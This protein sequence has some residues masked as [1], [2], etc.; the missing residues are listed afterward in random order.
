MSIIDE[1]WSTDD[2]VQLSVHR[3]RGLKRLVG[4]IGRRVPAAGVALLIPRCRAVHGIGL[5]TEIDVVFLSEDRVVVRTETLA[6]F[7][8]TACRAARETLEMRA[9]EARRL[10]LVKGVRLTSL[11]V[12][13]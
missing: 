2:G 9:G 8:T 6:P 1:Q 3:A 13:R 10:G 4:L 11:E 12:G 7:A 5:R